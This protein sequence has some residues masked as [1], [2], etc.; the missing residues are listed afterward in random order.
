MINFYPIIIVTYILSDYCYGVLFDE[1]HCCY[2]IV[3]I[4]CYLYIC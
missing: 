3:I 4:D 2:C 1:I